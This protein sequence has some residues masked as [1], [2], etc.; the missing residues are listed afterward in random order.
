MFVINIRRY[1]AIESAFTYTS[2]LCQFDDN[3]P[4]YSI[5]SKWIETMRLREEVARCATANSRK[6]RVNRLIRKLTHVCPWMESML[7]PD[8]VILR[9]RLAAKD[10]EGGG[11]G[12]GDVDGGSVTFCT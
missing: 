7:I 6:I 10:R 11:G 2:I 8:S 9:E 12:G 1:P 4:E 3:D 5:I